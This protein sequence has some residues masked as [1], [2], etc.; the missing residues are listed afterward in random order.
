MAVVERVIAATP[1]QIFAVLSDGWT[2]SDWVVGTA[3]I[4][5][6]DTDWPAPGSKLHHK[7][8]I[9]PVNLRDETVVLDCDPPN[10]LVLQPH[11]WPLGEMTAKFTLTPFSAAETKVTLDEQFAA[12]PLKWFRTKADDLMMHYRNRETLDRLSDLAVRRE[13]RA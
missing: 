2:Y 4:R 13:A 6:V 11:I 7:A 3:H 5:D 9:G 1:E 8:G 12:G 10:E